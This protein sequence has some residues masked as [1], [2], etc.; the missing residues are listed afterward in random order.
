ME[1]SA[2]HALG[3]VLVKLF[4]AMSR[5]AKL[6]RALQLMGR[7]PETLLLERSKVASAISTDQAPGNAPCCYVVQG[8]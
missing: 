7:G 3:S 1:L 2:N 8:Q 4:R 6:E 5:V